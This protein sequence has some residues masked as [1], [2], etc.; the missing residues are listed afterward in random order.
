M[1][2]LNVKVQN[3]TSSQGNDVAN[4]Y[5]IFTPIGKMFQ[6]YTT[7]VVFIEAKTGKIFLDKLNWDCSRT[8]GKYRNMF[9]RETK[10]ETQKK[11][12]TGEYT[13]RDLN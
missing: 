4:Q 2:K 1:K 3:M 13:L 8:T 6:S 12:D 11:I 7:V 9:L 5:E 10:K